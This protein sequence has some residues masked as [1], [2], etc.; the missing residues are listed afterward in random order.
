M[1][2]KKDLSKQLK[3]LERL[4]NVSYDEK[5]MCALKIGGKIGAIITPFTE[6][7]IIEAVT[8]CKEQKIPFHI[9]GNF[10]NTMIKDEGFQGAII[11]ISGNYSGFN[12]SGDTVMVRAGTSLIR[13][14]KEMT[15]KGLG[16][17]EFAGG[18]PGTVG[19]G[20]FMNA[21]AFEGQMSDVVTGVKVFNGYHVLLI[22]KD[23][24]EFSY[25][26]SAFMEHPEWIILEVQ[27][28]LKAGTGDINKLVEFNERR[29]EKQPLDLPN[30][31]S[32]FKRPKDAF[33]AQLIEE[34]GLKGAYVG[35]AQVSEKHSG[36]IVNTGRA[37]SK[38]VLKL[39]EKIKK[40]VKK[41]KGVDLELEWQILD[42]K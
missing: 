36:F 27:F 25:R 1:I 38:D 10:S 32:T 6:D 9:A 13:F 17:L 4:K 5:L 20:V 23:Q 40:T 30:L 24:L 42:N 34:C 12:I 29:A 15:Q 3:A 35:D 41:E 14:A 7:E 22:T 11:K 26:H 18:I 39:V 28:K 31:G 2:R 21:G 8:T 33:A 37:K 16:G 19:G